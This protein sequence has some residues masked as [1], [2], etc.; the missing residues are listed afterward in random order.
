MAASKRFQ[1]RFEVA[2][3]HREDEGRGVG[4]EEGHEIGHLH[5]AAQVE[6]ESRI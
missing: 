1:Q 5:V 2:D 4:E 3:A 6:F